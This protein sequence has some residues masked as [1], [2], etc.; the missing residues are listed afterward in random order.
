MELFFFKWNNLV[1]VIE[2]S[3]GLAVQEKSEQDPLQSGKLTAPGSHPIDTVG[4]DRTM[5]G[6]SHLLSSR[7]AVG[8]GPTRPGT[9][10]PLFFS[11]TPRL[12]P[13]G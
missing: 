6:N 2:K 7:W 8:R 12:L 5:A 10:H 11:C 13:H 3:Y 1:P 4:E 9:L